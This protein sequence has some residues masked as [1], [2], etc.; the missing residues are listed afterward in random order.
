SPGCVDPFN[1]KVVRSSMGAIFY[2]PIAL[3]VDI[4]L[5]HQQFSYPV[6]LDMR[7]KNL[8]SADFC[9]ADCLIFGNEARGVPAHLLQQTGAVAYTI[10]GS[11]QIDSLNLA[12]T[13]NMCVYE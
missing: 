1:G 5:L 2:V 8:Q 10:P 13:V 11:G 4:A 6:C 7:G 3:D 9:K 12:A